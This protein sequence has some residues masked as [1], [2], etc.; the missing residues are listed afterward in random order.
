MEKRVWVPDRSYSV[1]DIQEFYEYILRKNGEKNDN[2]LI[3]VY[4]NRLTFK[5]KTGYY[6]KILASKTM[7]LLRSTKSKITADKNGVNVPNL[8]I[9]EVVLVHHNIVNND[10]QQDSRVFYTFFLINCLSTIRYFTPKFYISR[11][12][13]FR[14]SY[15]EVYFT[16]QNFQPIETEDEISIALV[17]N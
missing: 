5:I 13:Y 8:Q 9:A 17:M 2:L 6:L 12:L 4:K 16:D 15:G 10:N 11:S 14:F 7:K 1:L 3:K